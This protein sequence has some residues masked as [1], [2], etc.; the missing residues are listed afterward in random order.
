MGEAGLR[1]SEVT[2]LREADLLE[3][4]RGRYQLRVIGKDDKERLVSLVK[5]RCGL[6]CC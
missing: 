4:P 3:P 2:A 5:P 1:A 6:G